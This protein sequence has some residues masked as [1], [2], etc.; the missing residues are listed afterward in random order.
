MSLQKEFDATQVRVV[1]NCNAVT[2]TS[3]MKQSSPK[4]DSFVEDYFSETV[5]PNL[6]P[7]LLR[8]DQPIPNLADE[9]LYLAVDLKTSEGSQYAV[10]EV[11]TDAVGVRS[12]P[13]R[14][15]SCEQSLY[16][17]RRYY[18]S[19]SAQVFRG[20]SICESAAAYCFKFS[21]DAELGEASI[22]EASL[23]KWLQASS[24]DIK[25]MRCVF[26]DG[27]M[28]EPLLDSLRKR[29]G[30][31]RY[32]SLIPGGRYHNSKDYL[33]FQ[34]RDPNISSSNRCLRFDFPTSITHR[35]YSMRFGPRMSCSTIPIIPLIT[36]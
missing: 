11:P 23:R 31:G 35:I 22:S 15:R 1:L 25:Q 2:S 33:G 28:P 14:P 7:I 29:L 5:L 19:L 21:R 27:S 8:D 36:S 20:Y 12:N 3:S 6:E 17:A 4:A 16:F 26:Y 10:I 9:S 18:Q 32:D 13:E 24:N 30:F 34:T